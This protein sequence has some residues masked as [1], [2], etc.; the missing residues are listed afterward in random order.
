MNVNPNNQRWENLKDVV[1]VGLG[2]TGMSVVNHLLRQK[3][4]LNVKVID[5]R[6]NPPGLD[7]LN[8]DVAVHT[9]SWNESWLKNA[10]LIVATLVLH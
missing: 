4:P 9:G 6:E 8:E 2:I 3:Q 1:V 5:T 7:K 10:D